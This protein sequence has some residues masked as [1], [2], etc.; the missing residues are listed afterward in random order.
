[1]AKGLRKMVGKEYKG[2]QRTR[3]AVHGNK[4]RGAGE[5]EI[6]H[7]CTIFREPY[8]V[9][10]S[11]AGLTGGMGKRTVR[12]RALCLPSRV[13][14]GYLRLTEKMLCEQRRNR[15]ELPMWIGGEVTNA[16]KEAADP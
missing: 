5:M 7:K 15:R 11:R 8:E 10:V 6:S 14:E 2:T 16:L 4:L 9:K 12:Q 3:K 1:M 13:T